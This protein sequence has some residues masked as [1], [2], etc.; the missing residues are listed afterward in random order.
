MPVYGDTFSEVNGPFI[1]MEI[2]RE[3]LDVKGDLSIGLIHPDYVISADLIDPESETGVNAAV[4]RWAEKEGIE[5]LRMT[6]SLISDGR[7]RTFDVLG[8]TYSQSLS[9]VLSLD[10]DAV[11]VFRSDEGVLFITSL[12]A[13]YMKCHYT[14][15][16]DMEFWMRNAK[17]CNPDGTLKNDEKGL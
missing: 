2:Y 8:I 1:S 17:A 4:R 14:Y 9:L 7:P 13:A 11:A 15:E 3:M 10:F 6:I 5:N 12:S 16:T